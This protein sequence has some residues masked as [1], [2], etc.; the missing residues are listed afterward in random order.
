MLKMATIL[1]NNLNKTYGNGF[2]ALKNFNLKINDKEFIVILGPSGCGKTTL[3]RVFSGLEIPTSGEIYLDNKRIDNIPPMDRKTSMV[4]QNYALYPNKTVF[5]NIAFPLKFKIAKMPLV[6]IDQNNP[7]YIEE[8]EKLEKGIENERKNLIDEVKKSKDKRSNKK[9]KLIEIKKELTRKLHSKF[10][11]L[12]Q[13]YAKQVMTFDEEETNKLEAEINNLRKQKDLNAKLIN[14]KEAEL[15]NAFNKKVK[16]VFVSRHLTRNEIATKV[17]ETAK[18]LGLY[19]YL[20]RTPK[21]LSGGQKQRVALGRAIVKDPE[22]FL[23][24][25]P[26]SNLD[27]RLRNQLRQEIRKIHQK[28]GTITIFVTHDQT[29]AMAMADRVV[30]MKDGEIQQIAT[31]DEIYNNPDNLFVA[32]F[33]GSPK[34]NLIPGKITNDVFSI[35]F[36]EQNFKLNKKLCECLKDFD[37]K[38]ITIGIRPENLKL[39]SKRGNVTLELECDSTELTN[40]YLIIYS[41][42]NDLK[43]AAFA[44]QDCEVKPGEKKIFE[45]DLEKACFFDNATGKRIL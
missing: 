45:I 14:E 36:S 41:I 39:V 18:M 19:P 31:P 30:V 21:S 43:I 37:N 6:E 38:E 28:L 25:E 13:K 16:P 11:A 5:D 32:N 22:I 7:N 15:D 2:S 4:F 26:F 17:I 29:E 42:M 34:M 20:S 40:K 10:S 35:S 23:M 3:L 9:L 44:S 27:A 1:I 12:D 33:I 24:D 8:A